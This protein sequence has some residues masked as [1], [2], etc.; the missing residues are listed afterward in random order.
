MS[1]D[2]EQFINEQ[3]KKKYE[4]S[5]YRIPLRNREGVIVEFA[6][7]DEKDFER[8]NA[9]KWHLMTVGY[10]K[11]SNIEKKHMTMHHFIFKKPGNKRVID[12]INEDKLDNRLSN[13]REIS[14]A[15]NNQNISKKKQDATSVYKG[16]SIKTGIKKYVAQCAGQ[17][18]YYG[19]NE[20]EAAI[21]YDIYTFQQYG[22][23]A[24]NNRLISYEDAMK[25]ENN[26]QNIVTERTLPKNITFTNYD[27][28]DRFCVRKYIGNKRHTYTYNTLEEAIQ[29]LEHLNFLIKLSSIIEEKAYRLKPIQRNKDGIA[30]ITAYGGEEILVS[31]EDWH[32][33]NRY[34]WYIGVSTSS[35]YPKNNHNKRMHVLLIH[36]NDPEKVIHH[37][38]SNTLDNRRENLVIASRSENMHQTRKR[39]NS[40]SRF[41]GVYFHNQ[42]NKWAVRIQ[43]NGQRYNLGLFASEIDAAKAYNTKAKELFGPFA[44]L[45]VIDD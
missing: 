20:T 35:K 44:N 2:G 29:K 4:N 13:L 24:N 28:R 41:F 22:R 6:L 33:L 32:I 31:D 23:D 14:R 40:A 3:I 27:G 42:A 19:D 38:N 9:H 21:S 39:K 25:N 17:L 15:V 1:V 8:V 36:N 30:V 12:H 5:P 7:V 43:K 37:K 11:C 18:L 45:N 10:A 34:K 16:V 26:I